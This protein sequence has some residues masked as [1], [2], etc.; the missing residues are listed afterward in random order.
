LTVT[1]TSP[2]NDGLYTQ[3][4]NL[5]FEVTVTSADGGMPRQV[6]VLQPGMTTA[7]LVNRDRP[8]AGT[9][10][11]SVTLPGP[12]GVKAYVAGW[13]AGG[14]YTATRR[15]VLDRQGPTVTGTA[16][17]APMRA[18]HEVDSAAPTAWKK[19]EEALVAVR[20]TDGLSPINAVTAGML[21]APG[22]PTISAAPGQCTM[23]TP[24]A[25]DALT[26]CFCFRVDLAGVTLAG[27]R[28]PVPVGVSGAT[29]RALN[30]GSGMLTPFQVTRFKW[31]QTLGAGGFVRPAAVGDG[32]IVYAASADFTSGRLVALRPNGTTAWSVADAGLIT[33]GPAVGENIWVTTRVTAPSVSNAMLPVSLSG[34]PQPTV[35]PV[36]S[37]QAYEGDL[38]L[39]QARLSGVTAEALVGVRAGESLIRIG[40]PGCSLPQALIVGSSGTPALVAR[41][42]SGASVEVFATR[43]GTS[44]LQKDTFDDGWVVN[45]SLTF[46]GFGNLRGLLTGAGFVGGGG[47]GFS[48]DNG[49]VVLVANGAGGL[50]G[51]PSVQ[52]SSAGDRPYGPPSMSGSRIW[53]GTDTGVLRGFAYS[54]STVSSNPAESTGLGNIALTTP[55]L[56]RGGIVYTTSI[57]GAVTALNPTSTV[58]ATL[59]SYPGLYSVDGTALGQPALDA[60]RDANGNPQCARPVGVLYIPSAAAGQATLTAVLVDSAGLDPTALWPKYQRDN[61]NSGYADGTPAFACQ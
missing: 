53:V 30:A 42:V 24:P 35:C 21:S 10:T 16:E 58:N 39:V 55:V 9:Y 46:S 7:T 27:P 49:R 19:D 57:E 44:V 37:G 50:S 32:G 29:D 15:I 26:G 11:L 40:T 8:D 33:A 20:V 54:G 4:T 34:Q 48:P 13:D 3:A 14:A 22:G 52:P 61:R 36:N 23:C 2:P 31:R 1:V 47:G 28:G 51:T 56:G 59:W 43:A 45:G 18:A 41:R 17:T 38:A 25:A 5:N 6:P 60:V 12:D